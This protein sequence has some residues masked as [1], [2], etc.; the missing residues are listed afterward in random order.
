MIHS[1]ICKPSL[2]TS[3]VAIVA[4]VAT[5]LTLAVAPVPAHALDAQAQ[6]SS[7]QLSANQH[8]QIDET[9]L[10]ALQ[11]LKPGQST[12]YSIDGVD[13]DIANVG[14]Q[15]HVDEI[16]ADQK[17]VCA[18]AVASGLVLLGAAALATLAFATA[19]AGGAIIAGHLFLTNQIWAAAGLLGAWGALLTW[20][21]KHIC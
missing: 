5:M 18:V 17:A 21:E 14:G 16:G 15:L 11:S 3:A 1:A 7:L 4:A 2:K 19:G 9:F 12:T 13:L 20:V 8:P 10:N 6:L